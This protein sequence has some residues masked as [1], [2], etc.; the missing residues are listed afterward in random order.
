MQDSLRIGEYSGS[1]GEFTLKDG[2]MHCFMDVFVGAANG[3][4]HRA[5]KAALQ[6][7]GGSFLGRTLTV[8]IGWGA[9]S[10]L[11]VEGST[12]SAVHVLDYVE[13]SAFA[14]T[15]GAPGDTTLAFTLDE[16]GVTPITIQSRYR[17]LWFDKDANSHCHLRI[18][19][20]AVPPGDDVTLVSAHVRTQGTFD[21]LPEGS[22]ITAE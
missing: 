1:Q 14:D 21:D 12:A 22:E 10:L 9:Q 20:S 2:A 3:V 8:G 7:Q 4:P 11:F 17:G 16:H 5:A 13:L 19:L 18:S 15:N 6:I